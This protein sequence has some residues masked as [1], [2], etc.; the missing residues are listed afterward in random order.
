MELFMKIYSSMIK[1]EDLASMKQELIFTEHTVKEVELKLKALNN[2][3]TRVIDM[4]QTVHNRR[5][6]ASDNN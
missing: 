1:E 4:V 6:Q 5:L 3:L 2:D